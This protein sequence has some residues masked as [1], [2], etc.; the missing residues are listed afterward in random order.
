M[1]KK[2]YNNSVIVTVLTTALQ[3][4]KVVLILLIGIR[5]IEQGKINVG[6]LITAIQLGDMIAAP[7]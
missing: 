4:A 7:H 3:V 6:N 2:R 1:R 5:L